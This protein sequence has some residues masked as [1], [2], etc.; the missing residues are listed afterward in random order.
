MAV[1]FCLVSAVLLA[2]CNFPRSGNEHEGCIYSFDYSE[3]SDLSYRALLIGRTALFESGRPFAVSGDLQ[4]LYIIST[5]NCEADRLGFQNLGALTG[6]LM[7]SGDHVS[8]LDLDAVDTTM[9][10]LPESLDPALRKLLIGSY[11][12]L[13]FDFEGAINLMAVDSCPSQET[14]N[15]VLRHIESLES[16]STIQY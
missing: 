16:K 12:P 14:I 11:D 2:A 9:C 15:F 13:F 3:N 10:S 8:V 1:I 6:L 5:R 7:S 4:E